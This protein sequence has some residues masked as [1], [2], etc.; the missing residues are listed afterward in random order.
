MCVMWL[1]GN[2]A[3]INTK[4]VK[5]MTA[6]DLVQE[7]I[8]KIMAKLQEN[9]SFA[10]VAA[11]MR[12]SGRKW[13][14]V[15]STKPEHGRDLTSAQPQLGK[16]LENK[17]EFTQEEWAKLG[18]RDLRLDDYI[19]AGKTSLTCF[20]PSLFISPGASGLKWKRAGA[21]KP[22]QGRELSNEML[23]EK[24]KS[25]TETKFDQKE[26]QEFGIADLRCHDFIKAGD[27]YFMPSS[28]SVA[29]HQAGL[30]QQGDRSDTLNTAE[31]SAAVPAQSDASDKVMEKRRDMKTTE[32]SR[33]LV[34]DLMRSLAILAPFEL[35][36]DNK[37][38]LEKCRADCANDELFEPQHFGVSYLY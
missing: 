31:V 23:A 38:A 8:V 6:R 5:K 13:E 12:P 2:G 24:L 27:W 11:A 1:L 18:V 35:A 26:W 4:N 34:D 20:K 32:R 21:T 14:K 30:D 37:E 10:D 15:G 36:G 7:K 16:E 33:K 19:M 3:Q 9:A 29:K 28:S 22:T 17:T 25:K